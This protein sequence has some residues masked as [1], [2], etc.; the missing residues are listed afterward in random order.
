MLIVPPGTGDPIPGATLIG[1]AEWVDGAVCI[2]DQ[3]VP[4]GVLIAAHI[5]DRETQLAYVVSGT[6]TFYVDDEEETVSEGGLV[7]R[8]AGSVH[9]LWN[10]TDE[11]ARMVEITTPATNWQAFVLELEALFAR[12][13]ADPEELVTLSERY[14]TRLTPDVTKALALR[15]GLTTGVGYSTG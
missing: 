2:L 6:L 7:V 12:G 3:T 8:P 14:G 4:P 5:H 11:P 10:A 1:R 9:A 15:H 13:D